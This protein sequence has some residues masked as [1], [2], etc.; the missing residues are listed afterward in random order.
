MGY[1][2]TIARFFRWSRL[3]HILGIGFIIVKV[4]LL[5]TLEVCVA[6][7]CYNKKSSELSRFYFIVE[8]PLRI[9]S[10]PNVYMFLPYVKPLYLSTIYTGC[11]SIF[12]V[13]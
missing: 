9:P 6:G 1:G 13:P 7:S 11:Q 2:H 8:N 3:E 4:G 5:L 10:W 12:E